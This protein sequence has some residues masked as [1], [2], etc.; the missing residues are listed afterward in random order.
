[1]CNLSISKECSGSTNKTDTGTWLNSDDGM[2]NGELA[3]PSNVT[4]MSRAIRSQSRDGIAQVVYYHH[5]VGSQGGIVDR[6][7]MGKCYDAFHQIMR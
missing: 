6:V 2:L 7:V 3:V 4:R 1:M 5:G